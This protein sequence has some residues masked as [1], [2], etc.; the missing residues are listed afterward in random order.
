M[1]AP[2]EQDQHRTGYPRVTEVDELMDDILECYPLCC[3]LPIASI[4]L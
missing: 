1:A 3:I 4:L 2:C